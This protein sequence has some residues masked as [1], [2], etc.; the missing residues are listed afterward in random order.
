MEL[1]P[2][3]A[4]ITAGR[5]QPTAEPGRPAPR[6]AAPAAP[7]RAEPAPQRMEAA[8]PARTVPRGSFVNIRV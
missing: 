7:V 6:A 3:P 2:V 5:P 1:R 4:W 8:Q